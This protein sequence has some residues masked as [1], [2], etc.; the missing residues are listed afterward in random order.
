[1]LENIFISFVSWAWGW[2][3]I[4]SYWIAAIGGVICLLV[5]F[6]SGEKKYL[7]KVWFLVLL[8]IV[9]EGAKAL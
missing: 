2:I 3:C 7:A 8:Y 1:M 6:L 9:V 4:L 5:Y